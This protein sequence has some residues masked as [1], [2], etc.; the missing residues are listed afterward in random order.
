MKGR[1]EVSHH[2]KD[3]VMM[4]NLSPASLGLELG[5]VLELGLLMGCRPGSHLIYLAVTLRI[6]TG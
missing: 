3:D 5:L 1:C 2:A 4:L 6:V